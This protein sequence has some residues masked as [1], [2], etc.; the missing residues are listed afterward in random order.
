MERSIMKYKQILNYYL[1][2]PMV[3]FHYYFSKTL[4]V[5]YYRLL[6]KQSAQC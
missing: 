4:A 5:W 3:T 6:K 2:F 1:L